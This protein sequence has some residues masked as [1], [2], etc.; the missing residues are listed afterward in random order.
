MDTFCVFADDFK[1]VWRLD[2]EKN[3]I[4]VF[5]CFYEITY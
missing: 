1:I 3:L 2:V 5:A 4:K